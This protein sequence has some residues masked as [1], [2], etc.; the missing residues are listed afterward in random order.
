MSNKF[1]VQ[2][3]GRSNIYAGTAPSPIVGDIVDQV[4]DEDSV[5]IGEYITQMSWSH[6]VSAPYSSANVLVRMSVERLKLG[7]DLFF[8]QVHASGYLSIQEY[9]ASTNTYVTRFY[10]LITDV[11]YNQAIDTKTGTEY[12]P[13][14]AIKATTW[15]APLMRGFRVSAKDNIVAGNYLVPLKEWSKI[16]KKV[17]ATANNGGMTLALKDFWDSV[18]ATRLH[19]ESKV[20]TTTEHIAYVK[21]QTLGL[22]GAF[23]IEVQGRNLSQL[24]APSMRGSLWG[25]LMATFQATPLIELFPIHT[26]ENNQTVFSIVYRLRAPHPMILKDSTDPYPRMFSSA[27]TGFNMK[28]GA[29]VPSFYAPIP[30]EV[31]ATDGDSLALMGRGGNVLSYSLSATQDRT[32]YIE[33]T[34]PYTGA[35]VLAGVSS[36]PVYAKDDIEL[37]GLM[38]LSMQYPYIR[39][40]DKG[41]SIRSELNELVAHTAFTY[42]LAHKHVQGTISSKYAYDQHNI[43]NIHGTWIEFYEVGVAAYV[44]QVEHSFKVNGMGTLEGGTTYTVERGVRI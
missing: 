44:T 18:V 2:V 8:R 25:V 19:I 34:S 42:G 29:S 35:N 22:R 15:L 9:I 39:A 43:E 11:T 14:I 10:G 1:R 23:S 31:T 16:T 33:I 36:D 12:A 6:S 7:Y 41:Q 28:T 30:K 20:L 5:D 40:K 17:L 13:P 4:F 24:Q 37:Y 32:N 27:F 26:I 21:K 38:E 3:I